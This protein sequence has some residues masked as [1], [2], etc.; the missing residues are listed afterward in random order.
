MK[1][2]KRTIPF[3]DLFTT[4]K[5]DNLWK[6]LDTVKH[7]KWG[8][9]LLQSVEQGVSPSE[10]KRAWGQQYE[11]AIAALKKTLRDF[12]ENELETLATVMRL[13]KDYADKIDWMLTVK[14]YP[15]FA[16]TD[17][18]PSA[19]RRCH[20]PCGIKWPMKALSNVLLDAKIL[21]MRGGIYLDR[22]ITAKSL[23]VPWEIIEK[24]PRINLRA[25]LKVLSEANADLNDFIR[26]TT[27]GGDAKGSSTTQ[28][29]GQ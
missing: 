9:Q 4:F 10:A 1:K 2:T 21:E 3:L 11:L 6:E 23:G 24:S 29:K 15:C 13:K 26:T 28:T 20:S 22:L 16:G 17:M 8:K 12:S 19:C 14:A 7:G 18:G 5:D 27:T 25:I